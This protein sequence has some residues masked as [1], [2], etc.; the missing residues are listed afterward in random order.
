MKN[1]K[2]IIGALFVLNSI[3][4]FGQCE[5]TLD[6]YS[7]NDCYGDSVGSIEITI[8]NPVTGASASWT[9]PNGSPYS[10]PTLN[11]LKAG[12]YY[13]TITNG[14]QECLSDS[15]DIE[16]TIKISADL[17]LTGRCN[18]QDSVD[19]ITTLW[20]GTPPYTSEWSNGDLGPNATNLSSTGSVPHKLIVTDKNGCK[21]TID[22]WVIAVKEMNPF[23][24]SVGTIC[25]DDNSGEVRVFVQEG[26][27]PFTFNWEI[28]GELFFQEND[29]LVIDS[30]SSISGL[31][32]GVYLVE[33]IDD[34]ECVIKDSIEVKSNPNICLTMYKAF[35]PNDDAIH[36]FWEIENIHLYPEAVVSVYDRNGR[37]VFRRRNYINSEDDA[38]GGKD[39]NNQPLPSATYYYV[40]D[41]ENGDDAFKGT[42]TI[43]R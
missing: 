38:F 32:P 25:K 37:Q 41:L 5:Y 29:V 24:S 17:N 18:D 8:T 36:E 23:M 1:R 3:L 15:I 42:V 9:G 13:L 28:G 21:D 11:Y 14:G 43:V 4:V 27:P 26:T 2:L 7:H 22:L 39:T 6:N 35:S 20:G 34:M 40:I 16:E 30:F 10:G 12:T 31:F 33:I 19:V